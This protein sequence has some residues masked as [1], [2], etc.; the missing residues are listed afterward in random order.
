MML[1]G[2]ARKEI[3]IIREEVILVSEEIICL[4][5]AVLEKLLGLVHQG[6]RQQY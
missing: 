2:G 1:T 3:I 6:H 4:Y 5:N